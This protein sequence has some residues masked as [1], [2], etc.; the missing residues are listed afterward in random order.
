MKEYGSLKI[1][2]SI[3]TLKTKIQICDYRYAHPSLECDSDFGLVGD[4]ADGGA[5]HFM[6]ATLD[7]ICLNSN[8]LPAHL[9]KGQDLQQSMLRLCIRAVETHEWLLSLTITEAKMCSTGSG[10]FDSPHAVPAVGDKRPLATLP[11]KTT[12]TDS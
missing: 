3:N 10:A 2:T 4:E 8:H 1:T 7:G 5:E 9:L 12:S 11:T 6:F